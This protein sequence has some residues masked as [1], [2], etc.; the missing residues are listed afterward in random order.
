MAHVATVAPVTPMTQGPQDPRPR[1]AVAQP[2]AIP[3]QPPPRVPRPIAPERRDPSLGRLR[4]FPWQG[5]AGNCQEA[6]E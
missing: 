3:P 6:M 1:A 4:A 2:Q 5:D